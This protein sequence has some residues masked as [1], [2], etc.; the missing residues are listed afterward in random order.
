MPEVESLSR[1]VTEPA[2][3]TEFKIPGWILPTL[4]WVIALYFGIVFFC[5]SGFPPAV[6]PTAAALGAPMLF[7]LFLPFFNKIKIGKV[8]ELEREVEKARKDLSEFKAETRNTL[9]VL[10]TNVNTIGRMTNQVTVNLP[11]PSQPQT[12][13]QQVAR[14][15]S[16]EVA[17]EARQ[18]EDSIMRQSEQ[19]QTW[20]RRALALTSNEPYENSLTRMGTLKPRAKPTSIMP[21][22]TNLPTYFSGRIP[23]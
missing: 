9:S 18:V 7:F 20:H 11:S 22:S 19:D 17:D 13:R 21:V 2:E 14:N 10:S 1:P 4:S 15:F 12:A 6:P 8:L 16:P 23:T 5:K 3:K